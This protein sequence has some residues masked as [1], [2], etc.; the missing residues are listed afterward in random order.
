MLSA[1]RA[2]RARQGISCVDPKPDV[3]TRTI[4]Y[5]RQVS[6]IENVS[7]AVAAFGTAYAGRVSVG[8]GR[9]CSS[10]RVVIARSGCAG[11]SRITNAWI[12]DLGSESGQIDPEK[13]RET[14]CWQ[15]KRVE[16]KA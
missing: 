16:Y 15:H 5:D 11:W 7:P 9:L 1:R 4:N 13:H 12:D 8:D 14:T 10:G 3:R 6:N 2:L